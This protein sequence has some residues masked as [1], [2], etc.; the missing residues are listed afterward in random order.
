MRDLSVICA[1]AICCGCESC[2]HTLHATFSV[3]LLSRTFLASILN[4]RSSGFVSWLAVAC[5]SWVDASRGSTKR[6]WVMPE[7]YDE[8]PSVH[9]GNVMVSRYLDCSIILYAHGS[10]ANRS[11]EAPKPSPSFPHSENIPRQARTISSPLDLIL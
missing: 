7:G 9:D 11:P 10:H 4:G 3:F 6:S 5:S 2:L 8:F 1:Q